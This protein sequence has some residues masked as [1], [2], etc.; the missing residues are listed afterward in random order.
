MDNLG[1][2]ALSGAS[3]GASQAVN[4]F[5]IKMILGYSPKDWE[6]WVLTV[7]LLGLE[8]WAMSGAGSPVQAF[9]GSKRFVKAQMQES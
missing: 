6:Y 4:H 9:S 3:I 5:G 7:P 8:Q 1:A 2:V